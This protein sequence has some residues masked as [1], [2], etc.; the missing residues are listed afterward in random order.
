MHLSTAKR[1]VCRQVCTMTNG[2]KE[3]TQKFLARSKLD[4]VSPVL[5]VAGPKAWK[6]CRPAY[7]YVLEQ[8]GL[9]PEQVTTHCASHCYTT[10]VSYTI[11]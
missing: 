3:V 5:D 10:S 1:L 11:S 8:L 9:Q 6:P 7:L 2:S 4:F